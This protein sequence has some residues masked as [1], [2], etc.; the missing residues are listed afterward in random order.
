MEGKFDQPLGIAADPR[1]VGQR[2]EGGIEAFAVGLVAGGTVGVAE[3]NFM[4]CKELLFFRSAEIGGDGRGG[5]LNNDGFLDAFEALLCGVGGIFIPFVE[6]QFGGDG[7]DFFT[8][9]V[10]EP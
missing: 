10:I 7:D 1:A 2:W 4:T 5:V 6:R 3:I 8:V 9:A